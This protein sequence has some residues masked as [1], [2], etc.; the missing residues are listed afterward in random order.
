MRIGLS[1]VVVPALRIALGIMALIAASYSTAAEVSLCNLLAPADVAPLLGAAQSGTL[2]ASG[3]TCIWG[4]MSGVGGKRGLMIQAPPVHGRA[5]DAFTAIHDKDSRNYPAQT[6]D[7]PGI[8]D[9]AFSAL[10]N[11]GVMFM[12]LTRDRVLQLQYSISKPGTDADLVALRAVAKK[13][14]AA[15]AP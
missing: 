15:F 12:V 10:K 1:V 5:A 7:E 4:D 3:L 2:G 11:Y 13:A 9:R 6:K 14:V 8:G